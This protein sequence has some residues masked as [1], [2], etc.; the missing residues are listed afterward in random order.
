MYPASK[1][2]PKGKAQHGGARSELDFVIENMRQGLWRLDP[3]GV[4]V[5]VNPFLAEWLEMTPEEMTGKHFSR[6]RSLRLVA[7]GP[8]EPGL[9]QRYHAEFFT[10]TG[11]RRRAIV[12]TS[13]AI[14]CNGV[15]VGTVDL[16]TDI[17]AEHAVQAQLTQEVQKMSI[18]ASTDPV[19]GVANRHVFNEALR[20]LV[21]SASEEPF[22]LVIV[23]IDDF[24]QINDNY[25]HAFGDRTLIEVADRIRSAVRE[26]DVVARFGGD[27]F[28][29]LL[30][31][32]FRPALAEVV[33]RIKERLD[34][35]M[36]SSSGVIPVRVAIGASHSDL[37]IDVML[38]QADREMYQ[39]KHSR[40][41]YLQN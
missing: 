37:D 12:V 19:T 2:S 32:T 22:G 34:F 17:T 20:R 35:L 18:L 13:P 15:P 16:I 40:R 27:E 31:N 41:V 11:I 7:E 5:Y 6:Y 23:D 10:S 25:G 21:A 33:E 8:A 9:S 30:P 1:P 4:I 28:A 39:R 3:F 29:A 36:E 24:K 14:D 26:N 38:Q